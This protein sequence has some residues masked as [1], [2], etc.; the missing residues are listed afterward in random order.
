[1]TLPVIR[2]QLFPRVAW[3]VRVFPEKWFEEGLERIVLEGENPGTTGRISDYF[4]LA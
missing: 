2:S 1:M 3:V 4:H